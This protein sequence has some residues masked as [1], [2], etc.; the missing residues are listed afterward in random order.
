MDGYHNNTFNVGCQNYFFAEG[1]GS[2]NTSLAVIRSA[3]YIGE[4]RY[5]QHINHTP[6]QNIYSG[7]D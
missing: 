6:I 1:Q 5:T 4:L 3:N 2:K 7:R